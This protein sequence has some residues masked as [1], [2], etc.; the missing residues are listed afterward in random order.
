MIVIRLDSSSM[1]AT[2]DAIATRLG[3]HIAIIAQLPCT[4]VVSVGPASR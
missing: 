4:E 3:L 2:S 1:F